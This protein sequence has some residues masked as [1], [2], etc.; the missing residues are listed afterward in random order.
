MGIRN[1]IA[2]ILLFISLGVLYP[3]LTEP[4]L[5]LEISIKLPFMDKQTLY[6]QTQS[7]L[8]SVKTLHENDNSF[9]AFLIL[10]FSVMVPII[11]A[12]ILLITFTLKDSMARYRLYNFVRSIGKWS[13]ADVFVVG[14]FIAFLATKSTSG[15]EAALYPGFY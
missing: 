15:L 4:I 9:V 14:I 8:E 13:M 6:S 1:W 5:H 2:L 3:G 12:V 11:K 10:L 7:I